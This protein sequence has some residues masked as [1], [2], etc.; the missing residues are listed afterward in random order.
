MLYLSICDDSEYMRKKLRDKLISYAMQRNVDFDISEYESGESFLADIENDTKECNLVF[1]DYDFEENGRNGI[2]IA[3]ELRKKTLETDL[4]FLSSYAHVVFES[5]EVQPFRFLVK[6]I[7]EKKLFSALDDYY[8]LL[9]NNILLKFNVDGDYFFCKE[10]E[11]LYI[12]GFGKE[13]IIFFSDKRSERICNE[14][15]ASIY[16]RLNPR[17]FI[18][19]HKSYIINVKYVIGLGK[20]ELKFQNGTAIPISRKRYKEIMNTIMEYN[21]IG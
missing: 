20:T 13:S 19:C 1:M 16:R 6:P 15:L 12:E 8:A 4:I 21:E 18:R 3:K 5:F 11:I 9:D 10:N 2:S 17:I 14:N 7:E